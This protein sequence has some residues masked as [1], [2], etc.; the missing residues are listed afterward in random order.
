MRRVGVPRRSSL[1]R[2]VAV[3][4][5]LAGT[6]AE[7]QIFAPNPA[8]T[9]S[10]ELEVVETDQRSEFNANPDG[11]TEATD[12]KTNFALATNGGVGFESTRISETYGDDKINNGSYGAGFPDVDDETRP[13][14]NA[15]ADSP[16]FVGVLLPEAFDINAI[17]FGSRFTSRSDGT[18]T[19]EVTSDPFDGLDLENPADTNSVAWQFV[20]ELESTTGAEFGRHLVV[21]EPVEGVTAVR[22]VVSQGGTTVT[23]IEAYEGIDFRP[24]P[25]P[26]PDPP[27]APTAYTGAVL[28]DNPVHYYRFEET[29]TQQ[30]A[31]DEGTGEERHGAYL[32]GVAA[33]KPSGFVDLGFAAE[34]DGNAGSLVDLGAPFHLG[35]SATIEAWV[36]LDPT[37]PAAFHPIVARWDG[38][39][40][41]DV[42]EGTGRANFVTRNTANE[43]ALAESLD[44][45][46]KGEW[47]HLVGIFDEGMT[48][49]Y[50]DGVQGSIIDT[51]ASGID[52]QDSG[53]TLFIGATRDGTA[54]VWKGLI[55]EVALYDYALS[56]EQIARHIAVARGG[57]EEVADR[58]SISGDSLATTTDAVDLS[59]SFSGAEPG[60]VVEYEW[61]VDSGP[62]ML[63]STD[64]ESTRVSA[65]AAGDVVVRVRANDGVC[66]TF[67]EATHSIRFLGAGDPPAEPTAYTEAVLA[68]SPVHY[69]RFEELDAAQF[70]KDEIGES[71]LGDHPGIYEG[72]ATVGEPSFSP[73]L[74]NACR[75]SGTPGTLVNLGSPF[76]LG[77]TVSVEAWVWL[78][79]AA[80][81]AF[82]PIAARWDGSY[83]LDFNEGTG[84]ANFVTRN[85]GNEFALAESLSPFTKGEWHHVVGIFD[86]GISTVYIDGMQ[87]TE[88]D[89]SATG[90]DLQDRGGT[91]LI[92]STRDGS[93]FLWT[94]LIDEVAFYDYALSEDQILGHI[95]ASGTHCDED[96]DS[97]AIDGAELAFTGEPLELTAEFSG[98]DPGGEVVYEW[99]IVSGPADVEAGAGV[100][101]TLTCSGAGDVVVRV[102][103]DD[104]ACEENG[105][106]TAIREIC[107]ES[108]DVLTIDGPTAA[109]LDAEV[110]L[111]AQFEGID[112][113][114]P[115]YE[116]TLVSGVTSFE[117]LGGGSLRVTCVEEGEVVFRASV[118]DGACEDTA[119]V[120]VTLACGVDGI[121]PFSRGDCNNDGAANI[122][123]GIFLLNFL[124]GDG[125][126]PRCDA[127]CDS[128]AGGSL[129]IATAIYLFNHLFGTGD[130]PPA[131]FETCEISA[132]ESDLAIGCQ[133][134]QDCL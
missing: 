116:W 81:S 82:H 14:I 53:P 57:C 13:W 10:A 2:A 73:L 134:P 123:D 23:E 97:V 76:H 28:E 29:H 98:A 49:V 128:G 68:D 93:T 70:A 22:I 12:G 59:A 16:G 9:F 121:G 130:P 3:F 24:P 21:F 106:A 78:D 107:C 118:G 11:G 15:D 117:D 83:E 75:F 109:P 89:T 41:L 35:A 18:F 110:L 86:E 72:D 26:D 33:G 131:P 124:F 1:G 127:A 5:A 95:A 40:E 84:N 77:S 88:V 34:F 31:K 47:H 43:F 133:N 62:G 32:G 99:S 115:S 105:G 37:A 114:A 48:T 65:T 92:G 51:S 42:N 8:L 122:A 30:P 100:A 103:A 54:F 90:F 7:A 87:G 125:A 39:Y 44:A 71:E 74:G 112:G 119:E 27:A 4:V 108:R 36:L 132:R 67:V 80:A 96:V 38:S 113:E 69:Y 85:S 63:E 58:V 46:T 94:G 64:G 120:E 52:L 6:T 19:L 45:F 91:L 55:D 25:P 20:G 17:G 61:S 56:E 79:P 101:A 111:T 129:N 60:A 50:V 102:D 104:G 126:T 66:A